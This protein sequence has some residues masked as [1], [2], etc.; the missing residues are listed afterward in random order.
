MTM[1][2]KLTRI[3]V[4]L[5]S[6]LENILDGNSTIDQSNNSFSPLGIEPSCPAPIP[7]DLL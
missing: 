1:L 5:P 2:S 4:L 7:L 6:I 3:C